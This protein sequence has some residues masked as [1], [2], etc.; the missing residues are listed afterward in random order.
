MSTG[1]D[2][3]AGFGR[4]HLRELR[5]WWAAGVRSVLLRAPRADGLVPTPS[6]LAALLA[7]DFGATVLVARALVPGPAYF[8]P[9]GLH[10]GWFGL[11]VSGWLCWV[12]ARGDA[13]SGTRAARLFGV[14]L[15]QGLVMAL[16]T[17]LV[18]GPLAHAPPEWQARLDGAGTGLAAFVPLGWSLLAQVVLLSR[19]AAPRR[20]LALAVSALS[21]SLPV[22]ILQT[23]P[24]QLWYP[25]PAAEAEAD[26]PRLR[27]T[28]A[29]M[30]RQ[31][32]LL[33]EGLQALAPQRPD[34]ID[35]YALTFAPY[36]DEDV[37]RRESQLVSGVMQQRFDAG[38]RTLQLV[39]HAAEAERRPW[40]TPLNLRRAIAA[41]AERMDPE[42]DLLFIHLTSHGA[43]DGR[44]AASFWPI[45][46]DPVTPT[47]LR[48]WLDAAG[49]RHRVISVSACYA[50]SWL[51]PLAGDG[52]LVMTAADAEHTSYGCGRR[53]ELTFFGRAMYDEE[54]RRTRS[55]EQAHANARELIR[56]RE[57]DAGKDDG[58]SNPQLSLGAALRPVL[59]RL[60]AELA[61]HDAAGAASSTR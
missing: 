34:R 46:V 7:V 44:L 23:E 10:A 6:L 39:N 2:S 37:F 33:A 61:A 20:G 27:V 5:H 19:A 58:Y 24:G 55:F 45:E 59:Q 28:Q 16:L 30:E 51:A 1:L 12:V 3:A 48:A 57:I 36:A 40:A 31:P 18:L 47:D 41:I 53:S 52:T 4:L 15:A 25:D 35:V 11:L 43:R 42:Q 21:L 32:Q 50:G 54:L 26:A 9:G 13:E 8:N 56:Q 49:I 38:G 22:A 14:L 17:L 29:L 60:E